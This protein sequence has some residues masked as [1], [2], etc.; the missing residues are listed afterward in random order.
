MSS[1]LEICWAALVFEAPLWG[2]NLNNDIKSVDVVSGDNHYF[3]LPHF[4]TRNGRCMP[5]VG[6]VVSG[7]SWLVAPLPVPVMKRYLEY[8]RE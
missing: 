5:V 7:V 1:R 2:R 6:T 3:H 8:Q 4:A